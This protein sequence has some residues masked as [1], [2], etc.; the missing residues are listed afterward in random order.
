[1]KYL[2]N[3]F[4]IFC[5]LLLIL[6]AVP[7]TNFHKDNAIV[8]T[9]YGEEAWTVIDKSVLVPIQ[10]LG[11][12][13]AT[14]VP[15]GK[16]IKT[17]NRA[18]SISKGESLMGYRIDVPHKA[19]ERGGNGT[20]MGVYKAQTLADTK[21]DTNYAFMVTVFYGE[22]VRYTIRVENIITGEHRYEYITA[23]RNGDLL[24]FNIQ[25]HVGDDFI[26]VANPIRNSVK[27]YPSEEAFKKELNSNNLE[28]IFFDWD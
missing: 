15:A 1:M 14:K 4:Y 12:R 3:L 26:A 22:I 19:F 10:A 16:T 18:W 24:S 6:L 5:G 23:I 13:Y 2:R 17:P 25:A 28:A 7:S 20:W 8:I 9:N 21:L 27:Y 11:T